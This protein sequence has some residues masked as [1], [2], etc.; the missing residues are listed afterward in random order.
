MGDGKWK[1]ERHRNKS[2]SKFKSKS[3]KGR[4]VRVRIEKEVVSGSLSLI[5]RDSHPG[6]GWQRESQRNIG[7]LPQIDAPSPC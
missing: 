7:G 1:M 4:E 3:M 2:K 6:T 5:R